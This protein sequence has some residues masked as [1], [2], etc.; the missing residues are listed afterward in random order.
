MGNGTFNN[1]VIYFS[2]IVLVLSLGV[3][4]GIGT[5][6]NYKYCAMGWECFIWLLGF[7]GLWRR[8]G[9]W[10]GFIFDLGVI[11]L[12][13]VGNLQNCWGYLICGGG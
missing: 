10:I 5:F 11:V 6:G 7:L 1:Y 12:H 3:K 4:V 13:W 2:V 9:W 8:W